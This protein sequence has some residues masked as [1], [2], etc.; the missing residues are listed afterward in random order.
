MTTWN[1]ENDDDEFFGSSAEDERIGRICT[2]GFEVHCGLAQAEIH[3]LEERHKIIGFHETYD[4]AKE[5]ALQPG[6]E[7]GYRDHFEV[8][9][10]IGEMIGRLVMNAKLE[11]CKEKSRGNATIQT[12]KSPHIQ[13]LLLT[14]DH[15]T[16][17]SLLQEDKNDS[18]KKEP[19]RLED[20]EI[21]VSNIDSNSNNT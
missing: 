19:K 21:K 16:A 3:A 6:F 8:S 18:E 13:A 17:N 5:S 12:R 7:A 4:A 10:R 9:Q 11:E 15:L 20:L 14:K 2:D 1:A